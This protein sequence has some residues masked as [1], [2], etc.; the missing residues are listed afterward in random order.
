M[1]LTKLVLRSYDYT[2][3]ISKIPLPYTHLAL[4]NAKKGSY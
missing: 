2:A 1:R 4:L 3:A